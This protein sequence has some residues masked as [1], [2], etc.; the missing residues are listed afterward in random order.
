MSLFNLVT[1]LGNFLL[2]FNL[3]V[4][5]F[6]QVF[7]FASVAVFHAHLRALQKKP[8]AW[9]VRFS[10]GNWLGML[11]EKKTSL[12]DFSFFYFCPMTFFQETTL[13]TLLYIA[14]LLQK[15]RIGCFTLLRR[16]ASKKLLLF[17][18]C[19]FLRSTSLGQCWCCRC[20]TVVHS[21]GIQRA[22]AI[23]G[24]WVRE[25]SCWLCI[26]FA[27]PPLVYYLCTIHSLSPCKLNLWF[28]S[29]L[30]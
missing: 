20:C 24:V 7:C 5:H 9:S 16:E 14:L 6:T 30:C 26:T 19:L 28:V 12:V 2:S 22:T 27:I 25:A 29:R 8:S 4:R 10:E 13:L 11:S 17:V 18:A 1:L 3:F 15:Y 23:K 21:G